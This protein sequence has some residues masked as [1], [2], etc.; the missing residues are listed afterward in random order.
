MVLVQIKILQKFRNSKYVQSDPNDTFKQVKNDLTNKLLV[1]YSG[2]ACEIEG[3]KNYLQKDYN[4]L[5]TVD[6]ICRSVPSPLLWKKY[7]EEKNK[8]KNIDKVYFREKKY[9]YKYSNLVMHGKDKIIYNNGIDTD[10]YLRA[11]FSNICSRP[12]CYNCK[13]KEQFHKSD[14]TIWDC[15]DVDTL[16]DLIKAG[17]VEK[18]EEK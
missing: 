9:G 11:F 2:T 8:N 12:S 10:P 17:L 5:I 15:F 4:N 14:F 18:V 7:I 13:F 1:L 3:L 6:V 16:Y